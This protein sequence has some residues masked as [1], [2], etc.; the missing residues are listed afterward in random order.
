MIYVYIIFYNISI[1][2]VIKNSAKIGSVSFKEAKAI[3]AL[4][5]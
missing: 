1:N 2:F 3:V 4:K 5:L